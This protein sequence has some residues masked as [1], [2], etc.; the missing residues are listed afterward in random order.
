[1]ADEEKGPG[2]YVQRVREETRR[3]AENLLHDNDRLRADVA[4]LEAERERRLEMARLL[5]ER[6][7]E[8][9]TLR[10]LVGVLRRR[11]GSMRRR[12]SAC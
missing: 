10:A 6:E 12:T 9:R 11:S 8:T 2:T 7:Q 5:T 4:A 1:M 3:Y